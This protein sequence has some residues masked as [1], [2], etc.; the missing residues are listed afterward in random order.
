MWQQAKKSKLN[1]LVIEFDVLVM[2]S[3]RVQTACADQV[4]SALPM[5]DLLPHIVDPEQDMVVSTNAK[6]AY[7]NT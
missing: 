2:G 5:I 7:L 6:R 4:C 3:N 1:V